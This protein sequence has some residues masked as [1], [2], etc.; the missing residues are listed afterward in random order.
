[1][2]LELRKSTL[3]IYLFLALFWIAGATSF[4]LQEASHDRCMSQTLM[5]N[6]LAQ[7]A[8]AMLGCVT[9]RKFSDVV[10]IVGLLLYAYFTSCVLNGEGFLVYLNGMRRYFGYV[11]VVPIFRY[12]YADRERWV[13][14][15]HLFEK[16][17]Y[18][19]LI[20]QF[21]C[22]S[23]QAA[24][25]GIGDN[26][27]GS[28]GWFSSG[29][30]S[31]L[32]YLISFYFMVRRWDKSKGYF[33]NLK[34]NWVLL[35]LLF[36]SMLNETKI[37]FIFLLCYFVFLLPADRFLMRRLLIILPLCAMLLCGGAWFYLNT[38]NTKENVFSWEYMDE[39]VLGR[40]STIDFVFDLLD[41]DVDS[42][43]VMESDY[44]RGIKYLLM[45]KLLEQEDHATLWGYGVGQFKGGNGIDKTDFAKHYE[46]ILRGTETE[47]F[48]TLIELG[49]IGMGL[50]LLFWLLQFRVFARH[51]ERSS[52]MQ[53]WL[54][55]HLILMVA[56]HTAFASLP[57]ALIFQFMVYVS[58]RWSELPPCRV[59]SAGRKA[60]AECAILTPAQADA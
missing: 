13:R 4:M 40:N 37:S 1:M 5:I 16:T 9:L 57:F 50:Y 8:I 20:I 3:Y 36:P 45:S 41:R 38:V 2:K 51:R 58:S 53:W 30:I 47:V 31:Q 23:Y 35:L 55:V 32:I 10:I 18:A 52:K 6:N 34:D 49:Y 27:G 22:I 12:M 54:T 21:P 17:L 33:D 60:S 56:Y 46:W 43:E 15:V 59:L 44:A 24:V 28:L 25:W 7:L 26:G 39:Y 11:F 29:I 48:D 14:F 42:E 19:F